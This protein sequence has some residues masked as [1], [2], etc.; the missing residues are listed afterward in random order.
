DR[1][2][3]ALRNGRQLNLLPIRG[4]L[5]GRGIA[6]IFAQQLRQLGEND[7]VRGASGQSIT[8]VIAA[9]AR[10]EG[11]LQVLHFSGKVGRCAVLLQE[12]G[13]RQHHIGVFRGL[14]LE[15]SLNDHEFGADQRALGG[16]VIRAAVQ[17]VGSGQVKNLDRALGGGRQ[18]FG[19][20]QSA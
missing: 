6:Q 9:L 17:R 2:E 7:P 19:S 14:S 18:N 13:G 8:L 12:A 1:S 3:L 15:E 10:A 5:R 16:I 11:L 20:G 4:D